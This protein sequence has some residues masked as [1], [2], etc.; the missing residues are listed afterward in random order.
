[1]VLQVIKELDKVFNE[2]ESTESSAAVSFG[3][4]HLISSCIG[5]LSEL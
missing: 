3:N 1:M 5:L 2:K 4:S